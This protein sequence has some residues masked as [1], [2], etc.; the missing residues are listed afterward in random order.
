MKRTLPP[1]SA[2][3][4]LAWAL[5]VSTSPALGSSYLTPCVGGGIK[6]LQDSGNAGGDVLVTWQEAREGSHETCASSV[7]EAALGSTSTGFA[8]VGPVSKPG[9][10]SRPTGV[11][12]D[13]AGDGWIVGTREVFTGFTRYGPAYQNSGAW[14]AFRPAGGAFRAPV[15]LPAGRAVVEPFLVGDQAGTVVVGWN[16]PGKGAYLVW[17]DSAGRLSKRHFFQGLSIYSL[18][19]DESGHLLVGGEPTGRREGRAILLVAGYAGRFSRPRIVARAPH[20]P[21]HQE[22]RSTVGG[23]ILR[24]GPNRQAI[25]AWDVNPDPAGSEARAM[26]SYRSPNGALTK[27]VRYPYGL[28]GDGHDPAEVNNVTVDG[29]GRATLLIER[30]NRFYTITVAPGGRVGP[31]RRLLAPE[32]GPAS[33]VGEPTLSGNASGALALAWATEHSIDYTLGSDL[34]GFPAAQMIAPPPAMSDVDPQLTI[35]ADGTV[36]A[37]WLR[38]LSLAP[39]EQAIEAQSLTPGASPIQIALH[40]PLSH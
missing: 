23:P 31:P 33:H 7:A 12:L 26:I 35:S 29:A 36:T 16:V 25:V 11:F 37:V 3:V 27:P 17:G 34:T 32:A 1:P 10:L 8:D 21:P 18:G 22:F 30:D 6:T 5:L 28:R 40:R 14:L 24:V 9:E 20:T 13:G 38:L 19:I 15:T 4:L 2:C 39:P